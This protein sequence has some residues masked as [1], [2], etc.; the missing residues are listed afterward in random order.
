M[1]KVIICLVTAGILFHYN[2]FAENLLKHRFLA[3]CYSKGNVCIIDKE[4]K[5]EWK[6]EIGNDVQ[7]TWLLPG[8]NILVS[9]IHGVK[10]ID[11]S[12]KVVWE[13][14]VPKE[15]Y[16]EIHSAQP[17]DNGNIL[18]AECGT[19]RLIEIDRKGKIQKEIKLKTDQECHLQFRSARKTARGTYWVA[20]LGDSKV[21]EVDGEGKV[22]RTIKLEEKKKSAHAV[23]ELPNGNILVTTGYSSGI[24]EI[25]RYGDVVWEISKNDIANAGVKKVGYAAGVQRLPNGNTVLSVYCGNPQFIEITP[26]KKIISTYF[27]KKLGH[28]SSVN[29]LDEKI[30]SGKREILR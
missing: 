20:F 14:K 1:K 3:G 18:I 10:E 2:L 7:D 24:K 6:C 27:N 26:D 12:K 11:K 21:E 23:V 8:G 13:Y 4:G 19:K 22:L 15:P 5:I 29:I 28:I 25:N 16:V 9:Y 30:I 17:L